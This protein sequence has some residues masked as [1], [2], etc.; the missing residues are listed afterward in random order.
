MVLTL[1]FDDGRVQ[2]TGHDAI[3][4]FTVDGNYRAQDGFCAMTKR[5]AG[6]PSGILYQGRS[7]GDT[8]TFGIVGLWWLRGTTGRFCLWPSEDCGSGAPSRATSAG[9]HLEGDQ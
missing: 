3:G 4:Q 8:G 9:P 5:Y 6:G 2:G 1:A 7:T